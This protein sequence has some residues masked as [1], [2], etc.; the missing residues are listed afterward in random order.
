MSMV[1]WADVEERQPRLADV[2]RRRL[3]GPGVVLV[4]TIRADGSPRLSPVEPLFWK[5]DLWLAMGWGS[6]KTG[7]LMRDPRILVHSIVT[8][9]DGS[10]GEFKVRGRTLAE[11]DRVVHAEYA[12]TVANELGWRPDVGKFHLFRVEVEEITFIHWDDATNDQFVTRWP[13]GAEFVRRGTSATSQGPP[14]PMS[15]LL[16]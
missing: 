1:R 16:S 5:G 2:G 6:R 3:G 10:E 12:E 9:R 8:D 11:T 4:A 14:E 15:D 13:P 7:D